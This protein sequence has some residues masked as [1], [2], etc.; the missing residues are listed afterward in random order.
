[1]DQITP[2]VISLAEDLLAFKMYFAACF[3]LLFFDF[4]LTLADE[5]EC[6][7]KGKKTTIF[8]LFIIN[9]YCPM[10][11]CII[12][13]FAYA[14]PFWTY[15]ICNR[16]AIVEWLQTLLIVVPAEMVLLLRVFALTSRNKYL[17]AFLT[18][19]IIVECVIVFYAMS[20]PGTNNALALPHV[21]ID[22]FHVC[23]L[24]SDPKMDTAYL[25][26]SI[27]Y[28]CIVFAITIIST[29][30]QRS[31]TSILSTIRRDG[32]IYFCVILSGNVVWMALAINGRPGLKLLNAQ[33]VSLHN[34]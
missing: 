8:Y 21:P 20:I 31:H 13:L 29:A 30:T 24:F 9:R 22:S 23:I 1:M 34:L 26:T 33:Y 4:F 27:A 12:T 18:S 5:V 25:S 15:E 17:F 2:E 19:I 14:S 7:W 32:T 6:I 28:D 3:A 11:F 16:F 10:A